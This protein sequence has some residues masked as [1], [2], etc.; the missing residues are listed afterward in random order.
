MENCNE[1]K[2]THHRV[3]SINNV[4][5][6]L[7]RKKDGQWRQCIASVNGQSCFLGLKSDTGTPRGFM[8]KS[9][10]ISSAPLVTFSP[11]IMML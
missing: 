5:K 10:P 7:F 11:P 4:K 6:Q 9:E 2:E 3:S 1:N 8:V